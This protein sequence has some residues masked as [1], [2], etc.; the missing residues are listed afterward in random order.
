MDDAFFVNARTVEILVMTKKLMSLS[1]PPPVLADD[2]LLNARIVRIYLYSSWL[3]T[4]MSMT[5]SFPPPPSQ[6]DGENDKVIDSFVI[7]RIPMILT[8]TIADAPVLPC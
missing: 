1:Y 5:L 7:T 3:M 6:G 2:F 4:E 8:N